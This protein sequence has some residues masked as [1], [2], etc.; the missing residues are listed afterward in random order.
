MGER[1]IQLK[2]LSDLQ[3]VNG[4]ESPV[5]CILFLHQGR[6]PTTIHLRGAGGAPNDLDTSSTLEMK[7]LFPF[8]LP[9]NN[10]FWYKQTNNS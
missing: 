1:F 10:L 3:S 7:M 4:R 9:S 5:K 8:E 2:T 6:L